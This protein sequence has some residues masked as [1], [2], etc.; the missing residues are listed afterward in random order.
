MSVHA[1]HV[2]LRDCCLLTQIG[3]DSIGHI[4]VSEPVSYDARGFSRTAI[5]RFGHAACSE[6]S[7]VTGL[8]AGC[9]RGAKLISKTEQQIAQALAIVPSRYHQLVFLIGLSSD[10][11]SQALTAFGEKHH[12]PVI[13]LGLMV[14]QQL[15]DIPRRHRALKAPQILAEFLAGINAG[16]LLL[17]HIEVLFAPEL[18]QDP[19][20][21]LQGLSRNRPLIVSWP[22]AHD[23]TT[24]LYGQPD[25]PEYYKQAIPDL[26][27][28]EIAGLAQP[29]PA[30]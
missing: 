20:R 3:C 2:V 24:L 17:D 26:V 12:A 29:N 8:A 11:R 14:S 28:V 27:H 21:L 30:Q 6:K 15:L 18:A 19:V 13:N 9:K 23:G 7:L 10:V 5:R 25:H 22:G 1:K 4:S 16:V